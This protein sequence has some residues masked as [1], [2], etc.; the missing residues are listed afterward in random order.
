M[1]EDLESVCGIC[2]PLRFG[3]EIFSYKLEHSLSLGSYAYSRY[4]EEK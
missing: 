3:L 4:I 1:K 2:H